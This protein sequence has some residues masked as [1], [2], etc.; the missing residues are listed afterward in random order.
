MVDEDLL[1]RALTVIDLRPWALRAKVVI[2]I[3]RLCRQSPDGWAVISYRTM[4]LRLRC[5]DRYA[6][7]LIGRKGTLW[8]VDRVL[9]R[10]DVGRGSR[11]TEF[12]VN[13]PAEWRNVPW[14]VDRE[15]RAL[16]F[17]A[18]CRAPERRTDDGSLPRS[19]SAA[20][21]NSL[22]RSHSAAEDSPVPRSQS[23]A[24]GFEGAA[25]PERGKS[26]DGDAPPLLSLVFK[27]STTEEEEEEEEELAHQTE[28]TD[29][30]KAAILAKTGQLT[31][32]APAQRIVRL[33]CDENLPTILHAIKAAPPAYGPPKVVDYIEAVLAGHGPGPAGAPPD[34]AGRA[35]HLR[36]MIAR[37]PAEETEELQRQLAECETEEAQLKEAQ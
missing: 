24:P 20:L 19:L 12:R 5:S 7:D 32:G 6:S 3:R 25:I 28:I 36:R 4:A 14:T 34:L 11:A 29:Q 2:E 33:A 21:D 30:I 27:P 16:I 23:A 13:D 10:G 26:D 35:A 9:V 1:D 22:P 37:L 31:F 18:S 8:R 15:T 17:G